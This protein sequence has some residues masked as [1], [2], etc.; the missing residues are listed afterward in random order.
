MK[1]LNIKKIAAVAAGAA[2]IGAAF[3]GAVTQFDESGVGNFQFF[4]NGEPNVQIVVGS[5]ALAS[6]AVAA[7]NI[8]G[9]IGN[10]AYETTS[11]SGSGSSAPV[12]VSVSSSGSGLA[13]GEYG[14]TSFFGDDRV[15]RWADNLFNRSTSKPAMPGSIAMPDSA[16][17][18]GRSQWNVLQIPNNG[19]LELVGGSTTTTVTQEQYLDM[20]ARSDY[21]DTLDAYAAGDF[22][23]IYRTTFSNPLPACVKTSSAFVNCATADQLQDHGNIIYFLGAPWVVSGISISANIVND[24]SLG[25][26]FATRQRL[27]QGESITLSTGHIVKVLNVGAPEGSGSLAT[28]EVEVTAPDGTKEA[29]KIGET[30]TT[31]VKG[32]N[33]RVDSVTYTTAP[34]STPSSIISAFSD[35]ITIA[36]GAIVDQSLYGSWKANLTR[37]NH[38]TSQGLSE[39][40]IYNDN[41]QFAGGGS[42]A[43]AGEYVDI[44]NSP[45]SFRIQFKGT[46]LLPSDYDTLTVE[47]QTQSFSIIKNSSSG[48]NATGSILYLKFHSSRTDA[49]RF[50]ESGAVKNTDTIWLALKNTTTSSRDENFTGSVIYYNGSNYV[51]YTSSIASADLE[52]VQSNLAGRASMFVLL[53]PY[54]YSAGGNTD[55]SVQ[56]NVTMGNICA[57]SDGTADDYMQANAGAPCRGNLTAAH[58]AVRE[59]VNEST[60]AADGYWNVSYNLD[61]VGST[62]GNFR[63]GPAS[64][65]SDQVNY[66]WANRVGGALAKT[67]N[68]PYCSPRGTCVESGGFSSSGVTFKYATKLAKAQYVISRP[69]ANATGVAGGTA[70][71]C[72]P[73]TPC[74]V[75]GGYSVNL[76][77]SAAGSV[78]ANQ[79]VR[80]NTGRQPLVVLDSQAGSQPQ[81]VVGGPIVNSV[82]ASMQAGPTVAAGSPGDWWVVVEGNKLLVAG[83][84]AADTTAA[85]NRLIDWM[86]SSFHAVAAVNSTG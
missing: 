40:A 49:W 22:W 36:N 56:F 75:G 4:T 33:V 76:P 10:N 5:H 54:Y 30:A 29:R 24:L 53:P 28:A 84:S 60:T 68:P 59:I 45:S 17:E 79:V 41:F 27:A 43:K 3:A 7:G 9:I 71:Q 32:I 11:V 81:I 6:D 52:R 14:V 18:V 66:T 69:R 35:S 77:S 67:V 1:S 47:D 86:A 62:D 16:K 51:N 20:F 23:A 15:D 48:L 78:E 70:V 42:K 74:A 46:D 37:T 39:I 55:V 64:T 57:I 82:A 73:G 19:R 8:A 13:A 72:T 21:D 80:I 12:S 50:T 65:T 63:N 61:G 85:A 58:I 34:S 2:M 44:M 25:K 38:S 26:S 31:K 83:Y